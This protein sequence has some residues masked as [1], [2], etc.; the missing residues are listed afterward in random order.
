MFWYLL[1]IF[2]I[3]VAWLWPVSI[4][5]RDENAYC[6][7]NK[8]R[9]KRVC[10][11]GTI[12]W[13]FL[14]G[15]R[16]W[17][18]GPDTLAYKLYRFDRT[19]DR[20][21]SDIFA[22]FILKY[23]LGEAIKDPGYPLLEKIFQIFSSDY[24]LWLIAIAIMFFVPMGI[25]VYKYSSNAA[26]SYILFST[27]FY[28][29]F[30]ITG[31]RQTVAT[32]IVVLIGTKFIKEYKLIKFLLLEL[33]ASTIHM[34][35]LCFLPFYWLSKL[36]INVKALSLYWIVILVVY[37]G[38][39]QFFGLLQE[40]I[41][42]EDYV[43]TEGARAGA[44]MYLLI[45]LAVLVTVFYPRFDVENRITRIAINALMISCV[46]SPLLLINQSC[47]RVV[48]YYSLFLLLLLPDTANIFKEGRSRRLFF[49]V[50]SLVMIALLMSNSPDY[51][52]CFMQL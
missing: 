46:F 43:Q 38:R 17:E 22:D 50:V 1:N 31:H 32:A 6:L 49:F 23:K 35:A 30:A 47:M 27:L 11:V 37:F 24:Q 26:V 18:I 34:S 14:S 20:S 16:S 41:G 48:Q 45:L 33:V 9:T 25:M 5:C 8:I 40:L 15:L 4:Y 12:N 21:W 19:L 3:V 2:I 29:F 42:Y 7:Y 10:I 36:K 13:V 39:N 44:F 28:S 52:F 51:R